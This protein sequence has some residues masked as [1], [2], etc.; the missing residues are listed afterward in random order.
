MVSHLLDEFKAHPFLLH[1]S[2]VAPYVVQS[3]AAFSWQALETHS[4]LLYFGQSVSTVTS[5]HEQATVP[6][7]NV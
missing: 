6:L 5:S 4:Q 7:V 1:A 3:T 2:I